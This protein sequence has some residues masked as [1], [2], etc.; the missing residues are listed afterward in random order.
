MFEYLRAESGL[1]EY[2]RSVYL[3]TKSTCP[4]TNAFKI[5]L[6]ERLNRF[7]QNIRCKGKNNFGISN[8][9]RERYEQ[10]R[11]TDTTILS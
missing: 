1:K 4:K 7:N 6:D 10:I 8:A 3:K 11:R 2:I 5:K 9:E